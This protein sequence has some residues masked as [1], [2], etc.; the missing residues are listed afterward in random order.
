M[1]KIALFLAVLLLLT[2]CSKDLPV[3]LTQARELTSSELTALGH[4]GTCETYT[5]PYS[6]CYRNPDGSK[7]VYLYAAPLERL[8]FTQQD[9]QTEASSQS[10]SIRMRFPD[11]VSSGSPIALSS[12]TDQAELFFS[13]DTTGALGEQTTLFGEL[14]QGM[15]YQNALSQ[16]ISLTCFPTSFGVYTEFTLEHRPE[17]GSLRFKLRAPGYR[18]DASSPDYIRL[19][20]QSQQPDSDTG[21]LLTAPLA[22]DQK[23]RWR[24]PASVKLVEKDT[25]TGTYTVEY[26]LSEDFLTQANFPLTLSQSVYLGAPKQADTPLYEKTPQAA[27]HHL[28]PYLILGDQTEKGEGKTCV[29]FPALEYLNLDP[30]KILSAEYVIQNLLDAK[31]AATVSLYGI[32]E[33]WCAIN[34]R[35]ETLP[36]CDPT[37]AGQ[38]KV[39]KK[40]TYSIPCTDLMK[41]ILKGFTDEQAAHNIRNGFLITCEEPGKS[42][43]LASGDH[44][45][46]APC[47]KLT[48]RS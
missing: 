37:P 39:K 45:L 47:L 40:G 7:T 25:K 48:V 46:Y 2:A 11:Q 36:S 43:L 34:S 17:K 30:E 42:L 22:V 33:N 44:G 15:A 20:K 9:S 29:R 14:R 21:I 13:R 23:G 3:S 24:F 12:P 41:D 26:S 38:V 35:W 6:T 19:Q 1:K 27:G 31:S 28:S 16:G 5:G 18:P 8:A 32:T 4:S 10:T